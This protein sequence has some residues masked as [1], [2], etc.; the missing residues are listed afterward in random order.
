MP[1]HTS[2]IPPMMNRRL[3]KVAAISA[4]VL[5]PIAATRGRIMAEDKPAA[6]K[7]SNLAKD[8]IGTW[9]LFG[10]PDSVEK[11]PVVGGGHYKFVTGKHW[12]VTVADPATGEV[13]SHHGGTYTLDGEN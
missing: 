5:A 12:S 3:F 9:V 13:T 1:A 4:L 7:S 6:E 10:T 2:G 11:A 8:L